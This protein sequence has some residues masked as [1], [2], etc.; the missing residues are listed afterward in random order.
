MRLTA[1]FLYFCAKKK[2]LRV[3]EKGIFHRS[4]LLLGKKVMEQ[5]ATKKAILFG[6]G[7]VGSWC[8][9]SLIRTGLIHLT[10]V[11]SDRVC[12]T[13]VNRQLMAT[14][15][16]VGEVK[17]DALKNRLLDINPDANITNLQKIYCKDTAED[18]KLEDYDIIIDAIDS[19][20]NKA[21]LIQNASVSKAIFVSSMGAALKIDPT[22]I[23]IDSFWRVNGCPLARKVRK[24]LRRSGVAEIDFPCI[25]SEEV[26]VNEGTYL[27]EE[28]E[29]KPEPSMEEGPGDPNLVHHKWDHHKASVNG[30][31][32]HITGMYGFM[33]AG[34]VIKQIRVEVIKAS[35]A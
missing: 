5:L 7:G 8:A 31:L 4:E 27:I 9:E 12:I 22:Q 14:S 17:T 34:L 18:F 11:D 10:I 2:G 15:K 24:M 25:Y 35:K 6:I 21:H 1:F 32:A 26:L 30:S 13:N 23:K 19:L 33:L 20:S 16:T 29:S 3:M 28:S